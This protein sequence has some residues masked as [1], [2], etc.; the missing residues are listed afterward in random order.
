MS[1]R[2][3][4]A[5]IGRGPA[6]FSAAINVRAR[7][8]TAVVI[9]PEIAHNPL[10]QAKQIDNYLG[11]E[12]CS[13]EDYLRAAQAH[14]QASGAALLGGRVLSAVAAGDGFYLSV[15]A[16]MLEAGAIV[17]A[18]GVVRTKKL[19]GEQELLGRG[20]SYCAT[21]DGML[22][23]GKTVAV[24]GYSGDAAEEANHLK[25]IGC[26]VL[27]F[28]AKPPQQL[29]DGIDY[30]PLKSPKL[31]GEGELTGLENAGEE[32]PLSAVFIIRSTIAPTELFPTLALEENYIAVNRRMETNIPG[33]FA[34]G[35]CTGQPLQIS[36]AVGEGL[37]AGQCAAQYVKER[38]MQAAPRAQ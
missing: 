20:V 11:M 18:N 7:G 34:A 13:G 35:D 6:G 5:I 38:A 12:A 14:V 21:C 22:F 30:L 24:L 16:D 29:D 15:G 31:L 37:I 10:Y 27:Y 9:G 2:F 23:R 33:V 3:D 4:V 1:E 26:K 32:I 8:K 25:H 19:P 36:K 28:A 17:L